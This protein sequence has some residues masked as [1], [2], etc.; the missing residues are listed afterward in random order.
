MNTTFTGVLKKYGFKK[1]SKQQVAEGVI[2]YQNDAYDWFAEILD[3]NLVWL[4]GKG[5]RSD[6]NGIGGFDYCSPE[7]LEQ[8]IINGIKQELA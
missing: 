2:A 7:D 5:L 6:A 3:Y 4:V 8:A 1:L